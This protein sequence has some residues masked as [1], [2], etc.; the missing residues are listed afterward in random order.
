MKER[1]VQAVI[2]RIGVQLRNNRFMLCHEI[3]KE[4]EEAWR[5]R[6]DPPT[7]IA[8]LDIPERL[9]NMLDR[10]GYIYVS[11]LDDI[12]VGSWN[13]VGLGVT[14]KKDLKAALLDARDQKEK[15][16][17]MAKRKRKAELEELC[18]P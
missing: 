11:D 17:L 15:A 8:E 4:L 1:E 16:D 10:E 9:I 12:N 7:A 13:L 14:Y 3:I 6:H 18:K 5:N 2:R